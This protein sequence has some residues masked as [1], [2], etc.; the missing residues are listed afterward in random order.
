M[1]VQKNI[2]DSIKCF[3]H[4][5]KK[6]LLLSLYRRGMGVGL[7]FLFL[8]SCTTNDFEFEKKYQCYFTFD[9]GMHLGTGLQSCLN[10][11]SPG[12]F[13]MVWQETKQSVRHINIQLYNQK[14][15]D[16]AITTALET[17]RSCTLGAS[18]G[19]I[20]G[21]S[22]LNNGELYAFDRQCP[23]CIELGFY[24]ALQWEN[25]GLW[26]KCPK[27]ERVYD[28]NN[29][30]FVVKGESGNKLMRYRA[31]FNGTILMVGN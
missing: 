3:F 12:L 5:K 9:C 26:L 27:C 20:I 2:K 16:V 24:K 6:Y 7:F 14:T 23:N 8:F 4:S 21:C 1:E 30:G 15:E 31:S 10:S 19:L 11:M 18:N 25:N 22:N 13:C 17:M 29:H 28:L